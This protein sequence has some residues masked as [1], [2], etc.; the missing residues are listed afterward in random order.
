MNLQHTQQPC[1]ETEEVPLNSMAGSKSSVGEMSLSETWLRRRLTL[2]ISD[3]LKTAIKLTTE[4]AVYHQE[5]GYVL[6]D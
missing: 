4:F 2:N 3:S 1:V 6:H 5:S